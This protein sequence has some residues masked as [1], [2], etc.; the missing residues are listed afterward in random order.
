M[1]NTILFL[2][3]MWLFVLE[4]YGQTN[5]FFIGPALTFHHEVRSLM[6]YGPG[7]EERISNTQFFGTG[8]RLQKIFNRSWGLNIGFNY[9]RRHYKM[10]IPFD[11]C[12]FLEPGENCPY[13]L[14]HVDEYGYK[15]IE[16]PL[17][18]SKFF[19]NHAN[20][21]LYFNLNVLTA[22][23]FQ[24]FY[25]PYIQENNEF[26]LFSGSLTS[27]VGVSHYLTEKIKINVEPFTR[28][29]HTQRKDQFL[30]VGEE[31]AWTYFDNLGGHVLLLYRL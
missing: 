23:D 18:I 22:Y 10:N 4:S 16:L 1:K 31:R 20:W 3:I 30:I 8:L 14:A 6:I 2:V 29:I 24:S 5:D 9:V 15:T 21:E 12:S 19:V 26:N 25:H 28:I 27:G 7:Y 17:G 13:V 11:Y